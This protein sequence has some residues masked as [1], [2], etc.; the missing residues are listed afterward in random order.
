[1]AAAGGGR[2]GRQWQARGSSNKQT[3]RTIN[4]IMITLLATFIAL[5]VLRGTIG[6]GRL[7]YSCVVVAGSDGAVADAGIVEDIERVRREIGSDS[8]PEDDDA[9][10]SSATQYYDHGNAWSTTNYSLGPRVTRWNAKRRQWL[11]RN[12]GFP[13]RDASGNPRTLLVTGSPPGPCDNPIGDHYLLKATKNKIDY[14]RL[15][16]IEIVHNMAHLDPELAGCWSNIPLLR[17][18]MLAH[19]EVEWVRWMDSDALFTDMGFELPLERYVG[20]NLIIHAHH[21]LVFKKRSWVALNTGSFLLRNCQWSL[22]LLDGWATMGPK[23]R[24]RD[25]AGKLLTAI[26]KGRPAFEADDQSTFMY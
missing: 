9:A 2:L 19:P 3:Q 11:Y 6:I 18:L 26:L 5:L 13:S 23:G 15:H 12:P 8:D 24:T 25:E 4:S 14:C 22:E 16:G 10:S 7:A 1:M 17:R 20:S 21:D